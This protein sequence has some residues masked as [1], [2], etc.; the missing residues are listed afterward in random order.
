MLCGGSGWDCLLLAVGIVRWAGDGE[1]KPG[2]GVSCQWVSVLRPRPKL[3]S[4]SPPPPPPSL[5]QPK[6]L[7][8]RKKIEQ[9]SEEGVLVRQEPEKK[10]TNRGE[11]S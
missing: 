3:G 11:R 7:V 8:T 2:A 10:V 5:F 6:A 9:S 1:V 4:F